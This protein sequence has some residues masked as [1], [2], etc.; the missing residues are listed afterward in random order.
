MKRERRETGKKERGGEGRIKED[1]GGNEGEK[2]ERE[3]AGEEEQGDEIW[4]SEGRKKA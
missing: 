4:M 3:T 1:E 2:E